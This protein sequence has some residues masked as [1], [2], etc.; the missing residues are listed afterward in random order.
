MAKKQT[1]LELVDE[2]ACRNPKGGIRVTLPESVRADVRVV[3]HLHHRL[4]DLRADMGLVAAMVFDVEKGLTILSSVI[5]ANY[6]T[7]MVR[8]AKA[9]AKKSAKGDPK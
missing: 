5:V 4:V 1:R 3:R 9:P 6:V 8:E 2:I 7:D